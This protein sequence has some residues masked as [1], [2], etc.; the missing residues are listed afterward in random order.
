[1]SKDKKTGRIEQVAERYATLLQ[2]VGIQLEAL[3]DRVDTHLKKMGFVW[4]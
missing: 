1:M 4:R 2:V 3:S